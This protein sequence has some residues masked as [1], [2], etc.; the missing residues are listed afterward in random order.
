MTDS[1]GCP[2]PPR[3]RSKWM[4]PCSRACCRNGPACLLLLAVQVH[5]DHKSVS[6]AGEGLAG[7]VLVDRGF[8]GNVVRRWALRVV[9]PAGSGLAV[10]IA[11]RGPGPGSPLQ[12]FLVSV[13]DGD[14]LHLD[15]TTANTG[16]F[17]DI[18]SGSVLHFTLDMRRATVTLAVNGTW[19]VDCRL[20][21]GSCLGGAWV[22]M[23]PCPVVRFPA[24]R[25]RLASPRLLLAGKSAR[26]RVFPDRAVPGRHW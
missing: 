12:H 3:S 21:G 15:V 17:P 18:T 24:C 20:C 23:V 25:R 14:I 2:V 19:R 4:P 10:G 1:A 7:H 13:S 8:V 5:G 16:I 26:P 22:T 11:V 6:G 9:F